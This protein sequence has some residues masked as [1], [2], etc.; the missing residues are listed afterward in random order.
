MEAIVPTLK[1]VL[2]FPLSKENHSFTD[3]SH[4]MCHADKATVETH[5]LTSGLRGKLSQRDDASAE[6]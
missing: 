2:F 4:K 5:R 1:G 6:V 3:N